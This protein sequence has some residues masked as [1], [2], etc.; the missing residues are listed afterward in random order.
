MECW[1]KEGENVRKERKGGKEGGKEGRKGRRKGRRK[2]K[3]SKMECIGKEEKNG[4]K[5]S[6]HR[7]L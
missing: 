4:K 1:S 3:I 7:S 6:P 5:Q 2:G